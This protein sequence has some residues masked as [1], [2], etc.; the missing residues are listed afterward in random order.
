MNSF[1]RGLRDAGAPIDVLMLDN[2]KTF[3]YGQFMDSERAKFQAIMS[4]PRFE[5][6]VDTLGID[7]L[8]QINWGN[9]YS[10][11]WDQ[12][13]QPIF[14]EKLSEAVMPSVSQYFPDILTAN[15]GNALLL[16]VEPTWDGAGHRKVCY[17]DGFGT[18]ASS[19]FYA[20]ISSAGARSK[21]DGVNPIGG[22]DFAGLRLILHWLRSMRA[23]DD[24]PIWPWI[25]NRGWESN[26]AWP[27]VLQDSPYW[28]EEVI[29]MGLAGIDRF[30][31][32]TQQNAFND[33]PTHNNPTDEQEL[34]AATLAELEGKVGSDGVPIPV[35]Q[36]S[37]GDEVLMSGMQAGD[38][39]IWRF[40]F[41]PHI[42]QATIEFEDGEARVI[43]APDGDV[44]AWFSHP[45]SR[46]LKRTPKGMPIV[47]L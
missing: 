21:P 10:R 12:V 4:D 30:L 17:S 43:S 19:Q 24:R 7:D 23:S 42:E 13:L 45:A 34:L 15:Y 36:H 40:T 16:D 26:P 29:H 18:H 46:L 11:Q 6:L 28:R 14:D 20:R 44:G 31:Y 5:D 1:M 2:E 39:V 3:S 9:Q 41:A 22:S 25:C 38:Q 32:W 33:E 37:F 8:T 47:Q 35:G 27:N